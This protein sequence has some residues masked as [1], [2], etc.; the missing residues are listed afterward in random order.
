M[1]SF[2]VEKQTL[3]IDEL[4][5]LLKETGKEDKVK[6]L[7]NRLCQHIEDLVHLETAKQTDYLY[8]LFNL[9]ESYFTQF[10]DDLMEKVWFLYDENNY[11]MNLDNDSTEFF[12]NLFFGSKSGANT[13]KSVFSIDTNG[14]VSSKPIN[15]VR[16]HI[17]GLD[18]KGINPGEHK[19]TLIDFLVM[20]IYSKS[21]IKGFYTS[22]S[23]FLIQTKSS[24]LLLYKC[25][26]LFGLFFQQQEKKENFLDGLLFI[27]GGVLRDHARSYLKTKG[28]LREN[29]SYTSCTKHH[30]HDS[31]FF[32]PKMLTTKE[33]EYLELYF[34]LIMKEFIK[35]VVKDVEFVDKIDDFRDV[36]FKYLEYP[37]FD[38]D[39]QFPKSA[40][41][42]YYI[43]LFICDF[44]FSFVTNFCTLDDGHL[45]AQFK[46]FKEFVDYGLSILANS[47]HDVTSLF[48]LSDRKKKVLEIECEKSEYK[49]KD[50]PNHYGLCLLIYIYLKG[51]NS[52]V[53]LTT[54][55]SLN[56]KL[57]PLVKPHKSIYESIIY[58]ILKTENN[59]QIVFLKDFDKI[60]EDLVTNCLIPSIAD[61]NE[62]KVIPMI[63]YEIS[64]LGPE[65]RERLYKL[66]LTRCNDSEALLRNLI[67]QSY[68][69]ELIAGILSLF[70]QNGVKLENSKAVVKQLCLNAC[71]IYP[72]VQEALIK[73][74]ADKPN[75][76]D[77]CLEEVNDDL[78]IKH[79]D[80]ILDSLKKLFN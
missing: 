28:I 44:V 32:K 73:L 25:I 33:C 1:E 59:S 6:E 63:L 34:L 67:A 11:Q 52:I 24:V 74:I 23:S 2:T 35:M 60:V 14:K 68:N 3:I 38:H 72:T 10:G 66:F 62:D 71:I 57:L 53:N 54:E 29:I 49:M 55:Q 27:I 46:N 20:A 79:K 15:E 51:E 36:Y 31:H 4:N 65:I 58:M 42:G 69:H 30:K 41:I 39:D 80:E 37:T 45:K 8:N 9:E 7:S 61:S 12:F 19:N 22:L 40:A 18:F 26:A 17:K 21:D 50:F 47:C 48:D 43:I 5:G 64:K 56:T 78:F 13:A 76:D 75:I 77:L 16:E 70:V